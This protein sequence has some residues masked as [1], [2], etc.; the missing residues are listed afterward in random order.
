MKIDHLKV[1]GMTCE[2]CVSTVTQTVKKIMGVTKVNVSL[3]TG[4]ATVE[5]DE[6]LTTTEQLKS[7]VIDAGYGVDASDINQQV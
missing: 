3:K 6:K 1:T 2:V 7:A 4:V 5:F